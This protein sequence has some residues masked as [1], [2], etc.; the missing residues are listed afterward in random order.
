MDERV[1]LVRLR[2]PDPLSDFDLTGGPVYTTRL[3]WK[4]VARINRR[5]RPRA[6]GSVDLT[7]YYEGRLFEI[8]GL[9]YAADEADG[10][11]ALIDFEEA[12]ALDGESF[13]LIWSTSGQDSTNAYWTSYVRVDGD[14]EYAF[15][16][17]ERGLIRWAL[18]LFA[19][20]PRRY[21][22]TQRIGSYDPTAAGTFDGVTLDLTFPLDFAGDG[23]STLDVTNL[24]NYPTP[25]V[26]EIYGPVTNPVIDNDTT[27]ES[28]T[29][30]GLE[31]TSTD[32]A[33]IDVVNRTFEVNGVSRPDFIDASA[34]DWF[35]LVPG[36]N[37]LRLRGSGMVTGTTLLFVYFYD[38]RI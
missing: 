30:E 22:G 34:T 2:T 13:Q 21:G 11:Q 24:G 27:G 5:A 1:T 26:F 9:I 16:K 32:V 12:I 3:S 14:L 28:I 15:D 10:E 6:H 7:R 38:A 36:D 23:S 31:L 18:T 35:D 4:K 25:P 17:E 19:E 33:R 29:T 37:A 8:S 20:D